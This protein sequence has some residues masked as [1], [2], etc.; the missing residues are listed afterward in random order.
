MST[1]APEPMKDGDIVAMIRTMRAEV[2][3]MKADRLTHLNTAKQIDIAIADTEK[4][5]AEMAGVLFNRDE[6]VK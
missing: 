6:D 4:R 2:T 1:P 5:I 3:A